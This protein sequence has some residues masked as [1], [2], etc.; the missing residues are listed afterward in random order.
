[1]KLISWNVNGL[2]AC[3]TKGFYDFFQQE[4]ADIFCLGETK[5]QPEQAVI[6]T[7]GYHQY[8]NSAV[9]KGYSGVAIFTKKEPLSVRYGLGIEEH[10]QEGRVITLEFEDFFLV[11]VYTPNSKDGL[12]RLD[13]RMTWEDAFRAHLNKLDESKPVIVCGDMNVAHQE[14]DLKNPKTNHKNPGFTDEER[15]KMTELLASGFIDSFRTLYPDKTDAYSWWSYRARAR[16]KNVGW[17]IDYFLTSARMKE[18]IEDAV[19]YADI[20]GS[21]HCPVGLILK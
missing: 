14:I 10:D 16:E 20:L 1:M 15:A 19:I 6:E 3:I 5:M 18:Q 11:N 12:L 8:W 7:P 13:Y 21:D 17:R 2:R 9:K 4:D